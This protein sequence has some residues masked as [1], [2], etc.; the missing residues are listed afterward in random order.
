MPE[1]CSLD[2]E[3]DLRP[4]T[5]TAILVGCAR[6]ERLE[7]PAVLRQQ[8]K[9]ETIRGHE[10]R[11]PRRQRLE[12]QGDV[13]RPG[14]DL[15]HLVLQLQRIDLVPRRTMRGLVL[16]EP[17][18]HAFQPLRDQRREQKE[19]DPGDDTGGERRPAERNAP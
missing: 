11:D 8:C 13:R 16:G 4:R 7:F 6:G 14:D 15:Q 19:V 10:T 17:V 1:G 18:A 5:R 3:D 9:A 12:C 2:L